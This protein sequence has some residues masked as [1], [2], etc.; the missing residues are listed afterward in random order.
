[1]LRPV[2]GIPDFSPALF[3]SHR[4]TRRIRLVPADTAA[5]FLPL[6]APGCREEE[7]RQQAETAAAQQLPR[8]SHDVGSSGFSA[9]GRSQISCSRHG[10][11][12]QGTIDRYT[13]CEGWKV[14]RGIL[15]FQEG[16]SSPLPEQHSSTGNPA[17]DP[18]LRQLCDLPTVFPLRFL[19]CSPCTHL[20]PPFCRRD[21]SSW[22]RHNIPKVIQHRAL[23]L[24]CNAAGREQKELCQMLIPGQQRVCRKRR[25]SCRLPGT[26]G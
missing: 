6:P 4:Y 14:P 1:M 23:A 22:S 25:N 10:S 21:H 16:V 11:R 12:S 3:L 24:V 2:V 18:R 26:S 8:F 20:Q 17:E 9:L 19:E 13:L 15:K 7:T 5:G